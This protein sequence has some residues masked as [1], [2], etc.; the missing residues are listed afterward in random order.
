[1]TTPASPPPWDPDEYDRRIEREREEARRKVFSAL[2]PLADQK[3]I[4]GYPLRDEP[5]PT[6]LLGRPRRP[7]KKE[8][9]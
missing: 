3:K 8:A 7:K 5:N 2:V 9:D 6:Q 1:M 4:L